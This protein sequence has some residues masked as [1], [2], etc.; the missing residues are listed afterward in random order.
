MHPTVPGTRPVLVA[1]LVA[2]AEPAGCAAADGMVA[3]GGLIRPAHDPSK[4]RARRSPPG[5]GRLL[6]GSSCRLAG[7]RPDRSAAPPGGPA[8]AAAAAAEA[9]ARCGGAGS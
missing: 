1:D 8:T 9:A 4:A 6:A 5:P 7:R 2:A 3:I